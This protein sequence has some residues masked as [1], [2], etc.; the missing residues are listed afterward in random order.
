MIEF[1][2]QAMSCGHCIREVT[3]VVKEADPA[4]KVEIDLPT[5]TAKIETVAERAQLAA[6]L[7]E[8]GYPP[9]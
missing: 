9:A 6:A 5:H 3:R 4:A 1:H 2:I 8:A 7:A